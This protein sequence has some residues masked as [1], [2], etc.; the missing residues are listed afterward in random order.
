KRACE[1]YTDLRKYYRVCRNGIVYQSAQSGG[2][3]A[4]CRFR[5]VWFQSDCEFTGKVTLSLESAS[6]CRGAYALRRWY[7][8]WSVSF[9]NQRGMV[10][11]NTGTESG[12]SSISI[13]CQRIVEYGY[14]RPKS[15]NVF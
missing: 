15:N 14:Q 5:V 12:L 7:A 11:Q 6:R 4:I 2:R 10:Y 13:R 1:K 8:S 9:A 3:N